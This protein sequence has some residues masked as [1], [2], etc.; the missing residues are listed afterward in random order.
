MTETIIER[1]TERSLPYI[2]SLARRH[3]NQLGFI[4]FLAWEKVVT[5]KTKN[6]QLYV[7][8]DNDDL[9]G[10]LYTGVWKGLGKVFQICIQED[11]RR[12]YRAQ[13]LMQTFMQ[14][15]RQCLVACVTL[16]VAEE[17]EAVHFWESIGFTHVGNT[18]GKL[19]RRKAD[20]GRTI[21]CFQQSLLKPL[22]PDSDFR[23]TV[24]TV[25]GVQ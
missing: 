5:Q 7:A 18:H 13:L 23:V 24:Q 20:K 25:H 21:C 2:K 14:T 6:Q 1:A 16:R 3:C 12:W 8:V 11:A 15:C 4:P 9:T 10:C 19:G 22:F 17:L